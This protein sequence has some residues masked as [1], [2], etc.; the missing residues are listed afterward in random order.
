[1]DLTPLG[2]QGTWQDV[3]SGRTQGDPYKWWGL[4]DHYGTAN[5]PDIVSP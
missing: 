1:M 3:P 2:R 5:K 4:H